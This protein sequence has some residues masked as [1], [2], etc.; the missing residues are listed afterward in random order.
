VGATTVPIPY[1]GQGYGTT[2]F[3]S[4]VTLGTGGMMTF[5][6]GDGAS[7]PTF[8]VPVTIPG[9]A[10][11]TSPL[12][13]TDGGSALIDTSHDLSV[14]WT[15]ITIGQI[16]FRVDDNSASVGSVATSVACTF[17]GSPGSGVVPQA[18]LASL[19]Q[20]VGTAATYASVTSELDGTTV[21]GGLTIQ[22]QGYQTSPTT[23]S[24]FY[25]TLQ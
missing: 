23:P 7:V 4:G 19:K 10:V 22:T 25:V 16:H 18:L 5:H 8:D 17:D 21:V 13:M 2:Y 14:T 11:V 12:P 6:G 9:L 20:M 24:S 3:P 15:P 1:V